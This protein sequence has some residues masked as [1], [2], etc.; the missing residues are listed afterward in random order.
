MQRNR[1][2]PTRN[3]PHRT[4]VVIRSAQKQALCA[5]QALPDKRVKGVKG[6]TVVDVFPTFDTVRGIA[7]D[8]MHCVCQ[9]VTKTM[10]NL[11]LESKN[12]AECF[13]IGRKIALIDKR[14]LSISPPNEMHRAPRSLSER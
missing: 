2:P 12:N 7:A 3:Y 11:W 6:M 5:M 13:Y 9:G 1:G 4:P 8:Y 14:L 10:V